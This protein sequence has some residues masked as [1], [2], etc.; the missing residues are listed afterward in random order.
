MKQFQYRL[1]T[2]LAYK[3]QVLDNLKIE[4]AALLQNVNRKQEEI[5]ILNQDL[6]G[7]EDDFDRTKEQGA[8]IQHYRLFDM[9]IGR[10]EEIIDE[11]NE[12]L[13]VL[14]K[15]EDDK[16]QEVISAKVDTSKFE[17]LKDKKYEEYQKAVAKADEAFIEEFVSNTA[18]QFRHQNRG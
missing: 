12:R 11:E 15:Q 9:R 13:K 14:K 2:V 10:M 4:H 3:T 17:K 1:E 16:K 18:R 5:R 6:V 8:T 7:M